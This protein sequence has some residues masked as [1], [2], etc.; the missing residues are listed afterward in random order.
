MENCFVFSLLSFVTIRDFFCYVA[1]AADTAVSPF[2]E[3]KCIE[4]KFLR[5]MIFNDIILPSE[6]TQ[7]TRR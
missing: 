2:D 3:S 1:A 4:L 6:R 7:K 5:V